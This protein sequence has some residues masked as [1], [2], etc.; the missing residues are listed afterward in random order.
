V[1]VLGGR[2]PRV[3]AEKI[4]PAIELF[5]DARRQEPRPLPRVMLSQTKVDACA[6]GAAMLPLEQRFYS[7]ML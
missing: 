6:I 3:L 5:D 1:I 4:I 2:I 7:S